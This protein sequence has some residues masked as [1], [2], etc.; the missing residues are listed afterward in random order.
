MGKLV[1]LVGSGIGLARELSVSPQSTSTITTP[2]HATRDASNRNDARG[3]VSI[4]HRD[5]QEYGGR[6]DSQ[7]YLAH[8]QDDL[9]YD[10]N[11]RSLHEKSGA[12]TESNQWE[13]E[14]S[15]HTGTSLP[16]PYS[17]EEYEESA[18]RV[19]LP[20]RQLTSSRSTTVRGWLSCPVIIPQR[21]PENKERGFTRAY[22]PALL[23]CGIDEATF[24][25]F[26]DSLNKASQVS[27]PDFITL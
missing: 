1:D 27:F 9:S 5:Y 22:A 20:T 17:V 21:R 3:S 12:D 6:T 7:E 10:E 16:P 14:D 25:N 4:R 8:S 15:A 19:M 18:N 23:N 26:L 2:R 24:L 11:Y 13:P